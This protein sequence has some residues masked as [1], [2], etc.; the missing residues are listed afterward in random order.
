MFFNLGFNAILLDQC[1]L[2]F[3]VLILLLSGICLYCA[4]TESN[5]LNYVTIV[6]SILILLFILF[7][8]WNIFIFL[9]YYEFLVI[10]LFICLFL[11]IASFF[12]VR[13]AFYFFLFSLFGSIFFFYVIAV[14]PIIIKVIVINS[15][16]LFTLPFLVKLPSFPFSY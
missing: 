7:L 15:A 2:P 11:F 8:L 1:S 5:T 16:I 6:L 12:K 9:I 10:I 4:G 14:L 3:I 13:T